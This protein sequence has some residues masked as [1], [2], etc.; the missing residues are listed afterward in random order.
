MHLRLIGVGIR[1]ICCGALLA[2]LCTVQAAASFLAEPIMQSETVVPTTPPQPDTQELTRRAID[3]AQRALGAI[4]TRTG[5][6]WTG[7]LQA[8][9]NPWPGLFEQSR[10]SIALVNRLLALEASAKRSSADPLTRVRRPMSFDQ[11]DPTQL[12]RD[13]LKL[14]RNRDLYALAR[15]DVNQA[16]YLRQYGVELSVVVAWRKDPALLARALALLDAFVD[17]RPLQRPGS[18]LS[19]DDMTMPAGGDGV[20]LATAWGMSG[21]VEMLD[22]LGDQVPAQLRARLDL[23]LR[24]EVMRICEDWA[25]RRPWFVRVHTPVS[26]QWLEPS[27]ALVQA[28]LH[29]KD[30]RLAPCYDLGVENIAQTLAALGSDGAFLE[31]FSYANQSAGPL[32]D[33]V[34]AVRANGDRR[35]DGFAYLDH[36]WEWFAHMNLGAG[37]LVHTYD[38][39]MMNRPDWAR[40][41]PT[42]SEASVYLSS[43]APGGLA[44]ARFLLP[45]ADASVTGVRYAFA[46]AGARGPSAMPLPTYAS[47]P[48]QGQVVWRSAWEAPATSAPKALAV[49]V[50]SGT[51]GENHVQ[52]D[53]GQITVMNGRRFVLMEAGTPDYGAPGYEDR[54][55]GAAGH[56]VMQVS[57]VL[58][59]SQPRP[60]TMTVRSLDES[61]GSITMDLASASRL[62]RS[63]TRGVAWNA[64][65]RLVIEDAVTFGAPIE[66]GIEVYRFHV[67][68]TDPVMISGS[69]RSWDVRWRGATMALRADRPVRVAQQSWP[70]A[71]RA[72]FRHQVVTISVVGQSDGLKLDTTVQVD[73]TVTD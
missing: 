54:Y 20:W 30:P 64:Q 29:L 72:P 69:G 67:G 60:C 45:D 21:I 9:P 7:P 2:M 65:G 68:S 34:R 50:R 13:A 73:R 62:A 22:L 71:I 39:R 47:F 37:V 63:S 40:T 18:T 70:D 56:S 58:P 4:R 53:N 26:N 52:R 14:Q 38:S 59:A 33:G 49:M 5:P 27:L 35:L 1:S 28:C 25:D 24:E 41:S 31:G 16:A 17:H 11:I 51:A 12:D 15:A 44:A 57:P 23:L 32:F 43:A 66:A 55:A 48:S 6:S 61:G 3:A 46:L 8:A 36:A 10:G 42:P 19:S